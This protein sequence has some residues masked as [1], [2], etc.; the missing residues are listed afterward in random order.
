MDL[1]QVSFFLTTKKPPKLKGMFW[2]FIC[3]M[4]GNDAIELDAE[5]TLT[6]HLPSR[7]VRS[8]SHRELSSENSHNY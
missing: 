8:G 6:R 5:S 1:F 3:R 4:L 7:Q 2:R